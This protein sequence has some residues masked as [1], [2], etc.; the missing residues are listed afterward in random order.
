MDRRTILM[1]LQELGHENV[2]ALR[3]HLCEGNGRFCV[4]F[5]D[6][7]N[8]VWVNLQTHVDIEHA[9]DSWMKNTCNG[10]L[11]VKVSEGFYFQITP[12]DAR[13]S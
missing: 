6:D 2:P 11:G 12:S 3:E 13:N 9:F 10:Q 7:L 4:R 8:N 5:H 1:Q